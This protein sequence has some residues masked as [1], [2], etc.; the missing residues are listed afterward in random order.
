MKLRVEINLSKHPSTN[1]SP[2]ST[3]SINLRWSKMCNL[4]TKIVQLEVY[5]LPEETKTT[6]QLT[7]QKRLGKKCNSWSRTFDIWEY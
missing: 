3:F 1:K 5:F 7:D 6:V 4:Q 2:I